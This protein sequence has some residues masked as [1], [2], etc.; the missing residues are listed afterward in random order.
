MNRNPPSPEAMVTDAILGNG[1]TSALTE[2]WLAAVGTGVPAAVTQ[3]YDPRA[4]LLPTVDPRILVGH[5]AIKGYF[6]ELFGKPGIRCVPWG[7]E[8]VQATGDS[9]VLSGNYTFAWRGGQIPARYT[10]VW[11][12]STTHARILTHHSS[13]IPGKA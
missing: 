4:V 1:A 5:E 3:L 9:C 12:F 2:R 8:Y 11:A 6:V 13:A 10:F 7:V